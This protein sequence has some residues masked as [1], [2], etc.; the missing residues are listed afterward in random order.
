[1]MDK[2][3]QGE[4]LSESPIWVWMNGLE[5]TTAVFITAYRLRRL[6]KPSGVLSNAPWASLSSVP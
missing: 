6:K 4:R 5:Q 2:M 3:G 1:M